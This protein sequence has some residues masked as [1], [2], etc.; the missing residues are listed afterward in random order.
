MLIV[1]VGV[2]RG[3]QVRSTWQAPGEEEI[4]DPNI[5]VL[6]I[7]GGEV[8]R[9]RVGSGADIHRRLPAE[10]VMIA[11]APGNPVVESGETSGRSVERTSSGRRVKTAEEAHENPCSCGGCPHGCQQER[12]G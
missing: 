11:S 9:S 1:G 8:V 3:T 2:R 4:G 5:L 7:V 6:E 10:I 12:A